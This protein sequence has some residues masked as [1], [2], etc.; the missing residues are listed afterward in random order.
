LQP[1]VLLGACAFFGLV[2]TDEAA[3]CCADYA[4]MASIMADNAANDPPFK[5]P[6]AAA[7]VAS[8]DKRTTA[9]TKTILIL[10]VIFSANSVSIFGARRRSRHHSRCPRLK[11]VRRIR[12]NNTDLLRKVPVTAAM[13]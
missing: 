11:D 3:H 7:G 12:R 9:D 6:L 10:I 13:S 8:A 4:V 5:Q 2:A 1:R